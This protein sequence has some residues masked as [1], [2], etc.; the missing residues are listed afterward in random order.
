MLFTLPTADR[1]SRQVHG[2]RRRVTSWAVCSSGGLTSDLWEGR[3]RDDRSLT[4]AQS[5]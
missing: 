2:P 1:N 5:S 3:V 4:L